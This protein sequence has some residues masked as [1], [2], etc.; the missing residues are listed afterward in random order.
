M[1]EKAYKTMRNAGIMNIA[2]GIVV[3]AIGI[4]AGILGVVY[5]TKLLRNKKELTF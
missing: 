1:V 5:G 4:T 2:V 3:M